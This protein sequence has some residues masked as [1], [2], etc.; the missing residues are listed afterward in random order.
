MIR[1]IKNEVREAI[2]KAFSCAL[3]RN[4]GSFVLFLARGDYDRIFVGNQFASLD[5]K[6]SPYCLDYML[7]AYK[8]ETRDQF[9]IRYLN[10]RY[11]HDDFK[12]LGDEGIDDLCVEMMIYSHVWESEAFLKYLYRLS[13]IVSGKDY[14]DWEVSNVKFHGY[15]LIIEI[16]E[17]LKDACPELYKII[18]TSYTGYIRDCFAHSLFNVDKDARII[19]LFC[20]RVK[21]DSV[22]SR[23]SFDEF[24]IK[25]LYSVELCYEFS[26]I[27]HDTRKKLIEDKLLLSQ[28]IALPDGRLLKI[29]GA[30]LFHGEP[31]FRASIITE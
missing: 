24:Q 22:L 27:F 28:P 30:E 11:K 21:N 19:E 7:D 2:C 18:D 1:E 5:P 23:L 26:H 12:Y 20:D 14:Y 31:R 8:D 17:K 13:N 29:T 15:P 6:P 10:R 3:H 4:S 16:K 25:F 9:Y